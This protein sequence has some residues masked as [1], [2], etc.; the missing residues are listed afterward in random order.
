MKYFVQ[1]FLAVGHIF[2]LLLNYFFKPLFWVFPV[3]K[4]DIL[5]DDKAFILYYFA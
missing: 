4:T 2:S 1:H 3:V 5:G